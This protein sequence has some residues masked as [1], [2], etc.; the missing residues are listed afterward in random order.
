MSTEQI[1]EVLKNLSPEQISEIAM[2]FGP[3]QASANLAD[4][5]TEIANMPESI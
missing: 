2:S 3:C 4:S 5:L 1:I